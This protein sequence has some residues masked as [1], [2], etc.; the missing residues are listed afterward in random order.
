MS[1]EDWVT[2]V[3]CLYLLGI[4]ACGVRFDSVG[5]L[6]YLLLGDL[7]KPFLLQ[8]RYWRSTALILSSPQALV[9]DGFFFPN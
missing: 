5:T 7:G 2:T 1:A 9:L 6:F 4:L 8:L 3:W